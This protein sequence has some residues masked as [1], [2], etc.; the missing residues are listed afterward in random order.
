MTKTRR[1]L[2]ILLRISKF[3]AAL[4]AG[5]VR[6]YFTVKLPGRSGSIAARAAWMQTMAQGF[7]WALGL[8]PVC[9]GTPPREGILVSNHVSYLDILVH[10]SFMP[11]VF[12][13]K[14]EV[15]RWPIFGLLSRW[16]GTLFIRRE[17]RSDVLR[18]AAEMPPVLQAGLVLAFFPEGTSSSGEAV[19]MVENGWQITPAFLR[20]ELEAGDGAV[21]DEVAYYRPETVLGPHLLNLLGK[22]HVRATLTYGQP[23]S[24]GT[25][26]K[27]LAARL[28]AEV[29]DLGCIAPAIGAV[30]AV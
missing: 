13:S 27:A 15:A 23:Q 6:Y 16:A 11:L 8:K 9:V 20:Y 25:D 17:L 19:P 18:V 2:R 30:E 24:P 3:F 28:H 29:C 4:A 7:L 5:V 12:I 10:A 22:R 26:R 1:F 21:E 14:A